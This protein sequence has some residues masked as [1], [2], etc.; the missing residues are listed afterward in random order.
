MVSAPKEKKEAEYLAI[1]VSCELERYANRCTEVVEDTG[2]CEGASDKNSIAS[3][4]VKEPTFNPL[5]LS[6]EW[7]S[8]SKDLIYEILDL[9]YKNELTNHKIS[10]A[11]RYESTAPDFREG[12]EERQL[13]YAYLGITALKL[14]AKLCAYVGIPAREVGEWDPTEYMKKCMTEIEMSPKKRTENLIMASCQFEKSAN[15]TTN[16]GAQE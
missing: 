2:F 1:L 6:V 14:A 11:F 4:Q 8:L 16:D 7:N 3:V 10:A 13:Q 9:P 15:L 12:F 5:A